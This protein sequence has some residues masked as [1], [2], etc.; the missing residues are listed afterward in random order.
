MTSIG[1]YHLLATLAKGGMAELYLARFEPV[2]GFEKIVVVKLLR[3]DLADA[4]SLIQLFRH[5]AHVMLGLVHPNIA[6]V[7]DV[8]EW[9]GRPF[10]VMEYVP[11][12]DV[13]TLLKR[14]A[15][16]GAAIPYGDTILVAIGACAGLHHAHEQRAADGRPLE[17]VHRDV[18]PANVLVSFDGAVK[19]VDF[20]IAKSSLRS[21]DATGV[22][23]L[24]GTLPYLS[25][26]QYRKQALDRRTDVFSVC[27]L[28]YEISTGT[29]LHDASS[30]YDVMRQI[31]ELAPP[32][33]ASRRADYPPALAEVVL[34]GLAKDPA[35]RWQTAQDLQIALEE[36][37]ASARIRVSPL[38][39]ARTVRDL[40]DDT[41]AEI[42]VSPAT[43]PTVAE[44]ARGSDPLPVAIF[45]SAGHREHA[46]AA[47]RRIHGRLLLALADDLG[48]WAGE[49]ARREAM[50]CLP[51][52][53]EPGG[54]Y[55]MRC[56]IA[57]VELAATYG[58]R[59][60]QLGALMHPRIRRTSPAA[61][62]RPVRS[63][64]DLVAI[65]AASTRAATDLDTSF[66]FYQLSS[67]VLR[68]ARVD[69]T[70]PCDFNVGLLEGLF[71]ALDLAVPAIREVRCRWIDGGDC[72]YDLVF[73]A[74]IA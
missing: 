55:P 58:V 2:P 40:L 15:R 7:F 8:G 13:R 44:P 31:L 33:P 19:L 53:L 9:D 65:E 29:R 17:I 34:A 39:L 25:P 45:K 68:I 59:P 62:A 22:G 26:E 66:R 11:G 10:L 42:E 32:A 23:E 43:A 63:V 67:T 61:F 12:C 73:D 71:R 50:T 38:S 48:V 24:R 57:L 35:A 30:D 74:P 47:E 52:G 14:A 1:R 56:L 46:V 27:V 54:L 20:G 6:Q 69:N 51:A 70:H 36:V 64:A 41:G 28:L 5:E 21:L 18:T 4:P 3:E 60:A 49:N 37:A 72:T 16:R